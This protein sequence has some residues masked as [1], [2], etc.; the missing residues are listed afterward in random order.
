MKE[1][2]FSNGRKG[3]FP[4]YRC[5]RCLG[6]AVEPSF[7]ADLL[8]LHRRHLRTQHVCDAIKDGRDNYHDRHVSL[9]RWDT[10]IMNKSC[11]NISYVR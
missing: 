1:A 10:F 7:A 11:W 2:I 8:S 3:K 4:A 6:P 5:T 9:K